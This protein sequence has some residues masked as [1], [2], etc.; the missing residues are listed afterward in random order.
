[1]EYI[2]HGNTPL[3]RVLLSSDGENLTGLWFE[4]QKYFGATLEPG[5][6]EKMLPVFEQTQQWLDLYFDGKCPDFMPPMAPKGSDFRKLVWELLCEIPY[7][8]VTTYGEIAK[9]VAGRQNLETMSA[10]A[11]GGAVSHNPISVIIPCHRVVGTNGSLT[12][13]AGGLEKKL[14]LMAL[15]K[16]DAKRFFVPK[17][18][19][20]L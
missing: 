18:G 17:K 10:Q 20:A 8:Q 5:A 16:I 6:I 15:E 11:V 3:G 9:T 7:G 14:K 2:W 13:Y 4:D 1:M 12:G 19:T